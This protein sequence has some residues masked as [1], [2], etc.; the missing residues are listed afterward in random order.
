MYVLFCWL[1]VKKCRQLFVTTVPRPSDYFE[2]LEMAEK[3]SGKLDKKLNT[4]L[5]KFNQRLRL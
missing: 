2:T 5:D 4:E 1:V 3:L